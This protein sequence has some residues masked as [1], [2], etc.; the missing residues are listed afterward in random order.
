MVLKVYL[1]NLLIVLFFYADEPFAKALRSFE[2][3]VLVNNNLCR[4]LF[5]SLESGTTFDEIF[6]ITSVPFYIPDFNL[7]SCELGNFTFKV[8]Y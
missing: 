2:T 6:K 1:K 7:L 4:K 5:S 8:L 3:C